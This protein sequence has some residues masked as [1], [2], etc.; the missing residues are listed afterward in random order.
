MVSHASFCLLYTL[1]KLNLTAQNIQKCDTHCS[2]P[3][4]SRPELVDKVVTMHIV[5]TNETVTVTSAKAYDVR[6]RMH[7]EHILITPLSPVR[8]VPDRQL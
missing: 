2:F 6:M 8:N 1:H 5:L 4:Q 7:S 3:E